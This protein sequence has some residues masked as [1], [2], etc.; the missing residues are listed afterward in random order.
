MGPDRRNLIK[1]EDH[2]NHQLVE[3]PPAT[4]GSRS[5]ATGDTMTSHVELG[6]SAQSLAPTTGRRT[7]SPLEPDDL[8][9]DGLRQPVT[10]RTNLAEHGTD[11]FGSTQAPKGSDWGTDLKVITDRVKFTIL[12]VVKIICDLIKE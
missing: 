12:E 1:P 6:P 5:S 11:S 7:Q 10:K 2:G 4:P 9:T 3:K 8:V